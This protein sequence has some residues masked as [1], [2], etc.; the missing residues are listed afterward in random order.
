MEFTGKSFRVILFT[1]LSLFASSVL[2]TSPAPTAIIAIGNAASPLI[3][4]QAC[5]SVD[6]TNGGSDTGFG[7]Y[8]RLILPTD[9]TF[10]SASFLGQAITSDVLGTFPAAPNNQIADTR[11]GNENISGDEDYS[12]IN[13]VLPLGSLSNGGPTITTNICIDV[14]TSAKLAT[15]LNVS[16]QP[17]LQYGDT[18]T[19]DNGS[20]SGS[21]TTGQITPTLMNFTTNNNAPA[22]KQVPGTTFG[23]T[24]QQ[25]I[26]VAENQLVTAVTFDETF[27]ND[28]SFDQFTPT[29][30]S[31]GTS[32]VYGSSPVTNMDMNCAAIFGLSAAVDVSSG[33]DAHIND[34]LDQGSCA[35]QNITHNS[36]LDGTY[37]A[38]ALPQ[39]N[40]SNSVSARHLTLIKSLSGNTFNPG[41]TITVSGTIRVSDFSTVNNLIFTDQIPDGLTFGTHSDLTI[42]AG[43]SVA[44]VPIS[45]DTGSGTSTVTYDLTAIS[46]NISGGSR[47]DYSYTL[48]VDV[49]YDNSD[50]ILASDS[51][52]INGTA[53][54][55]LTGGASNC[56][57]VD[58]AGLTITAVSFSTEIINPQAEYV[59]GDVVTFRLSMSVPSGDT[60]SIAYKTYFPLPIY[61]VTSINTTFNNDIVHAATDTMAS[62]PNTITVDAATNAL[63]INWPNINTNS[64]QVLAVDVDV[65]VTDDPFA[66]N[67]FLTTL[68]SG[69]ASNT[70]AVISADVNPVQ[71]NV[72]NAHLTITSGISA[73]SHDGTISNPASNPT[74]SDANGVDAGDTMTQTITITNDGGSAA[75]KI[76]ISQP[77][78]ADFSGYTLTA[79]T[80]NGGD[81]TGDLTGSL[82]TTLVLDS[83]T[84]LPAGQSIIL[85]YTYNLAQTVETTE[86]LQP[87]T[88]VTWSASTASATA[89]PAEQADF[90][91]KI[92]DISIAAIVAA[93]TPEGNLGKF[94]VGDTVTYQANVTLPEGTVTDLVVNFSL[95]AGLE[96]VAASSNVST[97]GF[98]GTI[99]GSSEVTSGLIA[100]GQTREFTFTGD[101]TTTNNNNNADN[102][103]TI[104]LD[105]LVKDDAANAATSSEQTKTLDISASYQNSQNTPSDSDT[106]NFTEH[107]LDVTT[108]VAPDNNLQPGDT[109]TIYFVI[110]NDGTA[111]AYDVDFS[112][113]VDGDLFDLTTVATGSA[114]CGYANPNFTCTFAS[115]AV[116]ASE[117]VSYTVNVQ[118]NVITG[119]DFTITGTATGDSQ[120]G[121]VAGERDQS[122]NGND[123][124]STQALGI[125]A[126]TVIATSE[127]FTTTAATE[128]LAIGETITYE[129]VI[130]IPEGI[131]QQTTSNDFV[132]FALPA[133]LQY[134]ANSSLVR[135][136]YDTT[137][138]SVTLGGALPS[139]DS[140]LEPTVD[141][142]AS[143]IGQS[144]T[145]DLG[146]VDNN[147]SDGNAEQIIVT[148][149]ALVLNTDTNT[150]GHNLVTTGAVNYLNQASA[151]QVD[152]SNHSSKVLLPAVSLTHTA[153][154]TSVEGS[155]VV[156]YTLTATNTVGTNST[157]GYD[158][159]LVGS[160]PAILNSPS[161]T[162]AILSRGSLD[163]SACAGFAGN[164]LTVDGSCLTGGQNGAEHYLAP[165]ESITI[166]YQGTVD[167]SVGFE[168]TIDTTMDFTITS[169]PGSNGAAAPGAAGSDKGERIGDNTNN[170]SAQAVNDLVAMSTAT[171]TA[172][173]P[174]LSLVSSKTHAPILDK[175]SLTATF[176]VP[177]GTSNN[178]IYTLDLPDGLHYQNDTISITLPGSNFSATLSPNTTPGAGTDPISLDF[179]TLSN[180]AGTAQTVTIV[181]DVIIDN[182][183]ANQN[184][185]SL[186][187][188]AGL[189][190]TGVVTAPSD[191]ATV[192]VIEPNLTITQLITA[193][194]VGSAVGDTI[195]YQVTVNNTST[196]ATA[197]QVNLA[198][199]LPPELLG[200]PDGAGA[201]PIFTNISVTNPANAIVLNNTATPLT[202]AHTSISTTNNTNDTLSFSAFDLP[203]STTLTYSY[204]VVVANGVNIGDSVI[205]ASSADYNSL[206]DG[207]GRSGTSSNDDDNDADLDNYFENDSSTLFFNDIA[208]QH[209][210]TSGQPDN[211]FA[212]G[213]T[214]SIDIRLDLAEGTTN[215][216][217][218]SQQIDSGLTFVSASIVAGGHISYTGPGVA[219][220][221]PTGTIAVDL[222][223][224]SNNADADN[225][226]DYLI[227]RMLARV[228]DEVGNIANTV[229]NANA[230]A[231]SAI[232]NAGPQILSIT[233]VEPNLTVTITPSTS[234]P[235][236]GDQITFTVLVAHNTSGA[237]AFDTELD[238][239]IPNGLTYLS[240]SFSGQ[241]NLDDNNTSLLKV[242]LSSI[243]LTDTSKTF[244]FKSS[245]DANATSGSSLSVSL[246]N[247]SGYSVTSGATTDDRDYSLS[248][249]GTIIVTI[250]VVP[251]NNRPSAV[252]DSATVT[253]NSSGNIIEVLNNDSDPDND[254]LTVSSASSNNG[255]VTINSNGSLSYTPNEDFFGSD[256]I[257]YTISDGNGG[258]DTAIVI[259]TVSPVNELPVAIDDTATV[260]ED[261]SNNIIDILSNDSDP[262]GDTLT[263]INATSSNGT[264]I[265]NA[266]GSLNYSPNG[267]FNGIDTINYTISDGNE[268]IASAIVS[269]TVVAANDPPI[270]LN[271]TVIVNED[272][273]NNIIDVLSND[274]DPDGDTLA[275]INATS[276]NGSVS[277]NPDS[278]L[279]YSP[280][281]DFNGTDT[282][283]YT[284][285]DGNGGIATATVTVN[286]IPA[287]DPPVAVDDTITVDENSNSN[288]INVLANDSDPENDEL[289]VSG[290]T[291]SNGTVT[292]NTDGSLSYTPDNNFNGTDTI[293][294][295][296]SDGNGGIA[297]AQVYITVE[298]TP[299]VENHP[300]I[301]LNDELTVYNN[302]SV[303]I[304]VLANDSDPDGH[305]ISLQIATTP[306]GTIEISG[307][308]LNYTPPEGFSGV[309]TI[310]YSIIDELGAVATATVTVTIDVEGPVLTLPADL[311]GDFTV[312]AT[313]LYT[314]VDLGEASAVDRF[315]NLLPVSLVNGDPLYPPGMNEAYWQ[316]TDNDGNSTIKAQKVC[317]K[318]LISLEKDQTVPEGEPISV[319]IYFNGI[320]PTYPV[321]VPYVVSG[322]ADAHDHDLLSGEMI[323]E[324]GTEVDI[325]FTTLLDGLVEG[326]E[327]II[328][329]LGGSINM[330]NKH[331]HVTTI[332]EGNIAPEVALTA[333][334]D[335]Q[336]RLLI[337]KQGGLATI[338]AD[339]HDPNVADTFE[340]TWSSDNTDITNISEQDNRFI[341][342]PK[343]IPKG[344]Y[345]L[346]ITVIDNGE[347]QLQDLSTIYLEVVD[348]LLELS[349]L[350]S[351]GDLIP[352]NVE[353]YKDADG[354]G[355]ADYLD[356][357]DECNVLSET[358]DVQDGYLIEGEP[359]VCLRRGYYTVGGE[360]GG[361]QLTSGDIESDTDDQLVIDTEAEN[362]GGVFD[363]IAYGM[364][365]EGTEYAI[366]MPQLKPVPENAVYRKLYPDTGWGNFTENETNSLWSTSGEPG[367]CPPPNSDKHDI[368]NIWTSGLTEGHWCVQMIIEDGGLNDDDG[369]VNG[370]I[371]DP[372][373][374]AVML[375][376]N[377]LPLAVDDYHS[378]F[379]NENR[380]IEVL[381]NDSDE[382][383]DALTIT[384][385]HANF[386][387]V[388]IVDNQLFYQSQSDYGGNVTINYGISDGEGG[389]DHGIVY[390]NYI[391][392]SAPIA[393]DDSSQIGLGQSAELNLLDNDSDIDGD[394]ISLIALD[395][396]QVSFSDNGQAV[397]TPNFDFH[398]DVVIS[399]TVTDSFGNEAT[400]QWRI[401]VS[402]TIHRIESTTT[403]G[404]SVNYLVLLLLLLSGV[405]RYRLKLTYTK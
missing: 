243:A 268:G 253:E 263:V 381:E 357:I 57:D 255:V 9:L 145:F 174:A 74:N 158:W 101:S 332:N 77:D 379:L 313:A 105:A 141:D 92:A 324:Q 15:P 131:S 320:S 61:D 323:I 72:R 91:I 211:N 276:S 133:G 237:D 278:S 365:E 186:T 116:G 399:Y 359:G 361:A 300:P 308:T 386:G 333:M 5:F 273:S 183:L 380:I 129:L 76:N 64:A 363:Y 75:Y 297:S 1:L 368:D 182:I 143:I 374:V 394:S 279:N 42:N 240:G 99:V 220:E 86:L 309:V 401:N 184:T 246:D 108:T 60:Q 318:P 117:T 62:T 191:T 25:V 81:I 161:L 215:G 344:L 46:G 345:Q 336:E 244:S 165:G 31:G 196:N 222:A 197:Y 360:T 8:F 354:D 140:A 335:G 2:A 334:Q 115:I 405:V 247:T 328:I 32:C 340:V 29:N 150:T 327:N 159:A 317:V 342:D 148:I 236:I 82:S 180:S 168:Q 44:I 284:I 153:N 38:F 187:A 223:N 281:E 287:N 176:S 7:P 218:L 229:L 304:D 319:G 356:R 217:T 231:S 266:D 262:D 261:S 303:E 347:P 382:D 315:G 4:S 43:G 264:V 68:F 87:Q 123:V 224:V 348:K 337:S 80:L 258:T 267:N 126:L 36:T 291:A 341:F 233:V 390:I 210:L 88:S 6:I 154:P 204:D 349:S 292:I 316:A 248:A 249:T 219:T 296:I 95:P 310:N 230:S 71:M 138:T 193:G 389:T 49:S 238:L 55:S 185:T 104:T 351:D 314:R 50:P 21:V 343:N 10:A 286:V 213:E 109:A 53:T 305:A 33:F 338:H 98:T 302:N 299:E 353:G 251:T 370:N 388:S 234:T 259:V 362:I 256:T 289:T 114:G 192:T 47:I 277:V 139:T 190:Y 135:A 157:N 202:S 67:L 164:N 178:F 269:V 325:T 208:L 241:G 311:C 355:V 12:L 195:S 375:S 312:D 172:N 293:T 393:Q 205:N 147:D 84:S 45:A 85:V 364:P 137:L 199:L 89:F 35:I 146:N 78:L 93:V 160:M 306:F 403:G 203:P 173:A 330:G 167:P 28:L 59:P 166:I 270:A 369:E 11:A 226:N 39:A 358:V 188:T 402:K 404:G 102:T 66:D 151:D 177:V 163:I 100:T 373:G 96:Y 377:H 221:A 56:T 134:I 94:V 288:T 69:Q 14:S 396:E 227:W 326:N 121:V 119:S 130:N 83:G 23:L 400:A 125:D 397:F 321:I 383:G 103:F 235:N 239:I 346:S 260:N 200:A 301:A 181:V 37:N 175:T 127:T 152:S 272:S 65:S 245:V 387:E 225:S 34:I 242:D 97:A 132:S 350:D 171:L 122:S 40:N 207:S 339:I 70:P 162:A 212:V 48:T 169:L 51:F 376:Q 295:T 257:T 54:Y 265:I 3:G 136:V 118:A 367:Y 189:S 13:L 298:P 198:E 283:T 366:V 385:T 128:P 254:T 63:I 395:N 372:G 371:V 331:Q 216:V 16:L 294:Y 282:I 170:D 113:I 290:A 41:D 124:A 179:G 280:N 144:L 275:V 214:V 107:D 30:P 52:T 206:V 20:I 24:Y 285:S 228:N 58:S 112:N 19:G 156:T 18:A 201:G 120:T 111:P 149:T 209:N 271:D 391:E 17:V 27:S 322:S 194:N 155:D 106:Q 329:S 274:S 79:A 232:G 90:D 252:D 352:D 142:A 378:L 22:G 384:S 73:I 307:D 110:T 398:G 392:N 250:P 26:N